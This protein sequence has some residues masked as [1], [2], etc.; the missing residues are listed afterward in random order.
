MILQSREIPKYK[1]LFHLFVTNGI[2]SPQTLVIILKEELVQAM[3]IDL[4]FMDNSLYKQ[5][6]GGR[7]EPILENIKAIYESKKIALEIT[8]LVISGFNKPG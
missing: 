3:N 4:K 8:N 5:I 2:I 6:T 1:K 7:L